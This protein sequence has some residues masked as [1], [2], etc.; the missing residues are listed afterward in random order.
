MSKKRHYY[1]MYNEKRINDEVEYKCMVH[2]VHS[3]VP[4]RVLTC[5]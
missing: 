5:N 2:I 4:R 1:I 3:H